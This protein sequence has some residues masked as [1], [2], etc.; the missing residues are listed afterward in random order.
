MQKVWQWTVYRGGSAKGMGGDFYIQEK[1]V[2]RILLGQE[3]K[4]RLRS[5]VALEDAC[6]W[7]WVRWLWRYI[8]FAGRNHFEN[9][10]LAFLVMVILSNGRLLI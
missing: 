5:V 2:W 10:L 6:Q 8:F 7:G 3:W 4:G 9:Q 1:C